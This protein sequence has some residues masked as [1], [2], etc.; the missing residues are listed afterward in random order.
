MNPQPYSC[1]LSNLTHFTYTAI[2]PFYNHVDTI[3]K[4]VRLMPRL[5]HFTT[6]V[7]P[8]PESSVV[9]DELALA[10]GHIDLNDAWMEFDTVY[11]LVAHTV[12]YLGLEGVLEEFR[13]DDVKMEGIRENLEEVLSQRLQEWWNYAGAGVWRRKERK[14]GEEIEGERQVH[15]HVSIGEVST[16]AVV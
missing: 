9:E 1:L 5:T 2:F 4:S 13:V 6:K 12:I 8:E 14:K 11:T 3:L 16:A 10:L 7:C 15:N